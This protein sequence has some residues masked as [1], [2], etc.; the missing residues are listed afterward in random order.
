[1]RAFLSVS[2]FRGVKFRVGL[3]PR[4]CV[5][6]HPPF[7]L[8]QVIR[9]SLQRS[10]ESTIKGRQTLQFIPSAGDSQVDAR[11]GDTRKRREYKQNVLA[12]MRRIGKCLI[13]G[14]VTQ[15]ARKCCSRTL[16]STLLNRTIIRVSLFQ[17]NTQRE[18]IRIFQPMLRILHI[19][20]VV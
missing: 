16:L 6:L 3:R 15:E 9:W 8:V 19:R 10:Q 18:R 17:S 14:H 1:M 7:P 20:T 12:T 5:L 2:F 11:Q 13:F 4:T